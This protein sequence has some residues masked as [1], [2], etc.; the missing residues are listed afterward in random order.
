MHPQDK[1][2][3]ENQS[4]YNSNSNNNKE[5]NRGEEVAL[6]PVCQTNNNNNNR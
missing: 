1:E 5:C 3:P 2:E 4:V 6:D